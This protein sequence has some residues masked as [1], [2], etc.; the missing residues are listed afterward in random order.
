MH[1][2]K[3]KLNIL[4][5]AVILSYGFLFVVSATATENENRTI[6]A[7]GTI[8]RDGA[9][10]TLYDDGV[11]EVGGGTMFYNLQWWSPWDQYREY[12]RSIVFTE[13]VI[14]RIGLAGLFA[15]LP[16]LTHI[17]NAGYID[18]SDVMDMSH[19]FENSVNLMSIDTSNWNTGNVTDMKR[20]FA[21]T[22]ITNIDVSGWDTGSVTNMQMMFWRARG[23]S[24]FDISD[25]DTSNVVNMSSMFNSATI[26]TLDLSN[27]DTSNVTQMASMFNGA[28]MLTELD[29]SNW[30]TSNVR[31]MG[32]MF[33]NASQLRVLTVGTDFTPP[34]WFHLPEITS[35]DVYTGFW[36]NVGTGTTEEPNGTSILLSWQLANHL[37]TTTIAD[38]FVWQRQLSLPL[39]TYHVVQ[40]GDTLSELAVRYETTVVELVRLNNIENPNFILVGQILTLP[41]IY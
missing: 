10:W 18:T 2:R 16:E 28:Y 25:W 8:G 31:H 17:E 4:L 40:W 13:P 9:E 5:L 6:I 39:V 34:T 26:E 20:M 29:I 33:D 38:T 41:S 32:H 37:Y 30:D 21:G 22:R 11:V 27:W 15:F 7:T 3:I 23:L 19:M 35:T 14:A 12:V 36:Q 1:R 24:N